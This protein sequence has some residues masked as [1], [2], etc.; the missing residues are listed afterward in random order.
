MGRQAHL[1][2]TFALNFISLLLSK[3]TPRQGEL[4]MSSNLKQLVP[5]GSLDVGVI[6]TPQQSESTRKDTQTIARGWKLES[7][8]SASKKLLGASS[9]LENEVAT[10][11]KY[12][13]E[14]LAVKDRGWKVCRLPRERQ[15]L[16]VQ[17]GFLEGKNRYAV[18]LLSS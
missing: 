18:P 3:H 9:K 7:F 13:E 1:E 16:G 8:N 14:V 4:S 11:T 6:K 2:A 5:L 17:Y 12:W 15:A 10:E